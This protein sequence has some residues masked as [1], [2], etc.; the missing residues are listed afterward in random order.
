MPPII[1]AFGINCQDLFAITVLSYRSMPFETSAIIFAK[2][3]RRKVAG[4]CVN[5][6]Q[7]PCCCAIPKFK[8]QRKPLPSGTQDI[9]KHL[10]EG[11]NV[12]CWPIP[13][14]EAFWNRMVD[15]KY[16]GI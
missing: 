7:F 12:I 5:C 3:G 11:H 4:L 6:G 8:C 15:G 10:R 16:V 14:R 1:R 2:K 9:A 13:S